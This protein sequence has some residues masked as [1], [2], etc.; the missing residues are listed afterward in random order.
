MDRQDNESPLRAFFPQFQNQAVNDA[1]DRLV[2]GIN[3]RRER[4]G[5]A[6]FTLTGCHPRAG[7]TSF[8]ARLSAAMVT[9]GR[10]TVLINAD[11]RKSA[12]P[13]AQNRKPAF[14][15]SDY[16][17]GGAAAE[18][19]I[20]GTNLENLSYIAS[21]GQRFNAVKL[22][23]ANRMELLIQS[24]KERFEILL[25]DTPSVNSVVDAA[26]L[27]RKTDAAVLIARHRV[28][29]TTQIE[30]AKRE[31]DQVGANLLGIVLNQV[32]KHTYR[33]FLKNYHDLGLK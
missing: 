7:T 5:M 32:D 31:L 4:D 13:A 11:M 26:I 33:D 20:R 28:T 19:I 21:G 29:K 9:S 23:Y 1:Y 6:S 25:F 16:L 18:E 14:G 15:L 22:L 10:K 2:A 8:A 27:A 12:E 24:L 30:N 3:A 17:S